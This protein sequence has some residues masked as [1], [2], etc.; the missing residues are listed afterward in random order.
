[1]CDVGIAVFPR[2]L[3]YWNPRVALPN[4]DVHTFLVGDEKG[5]DVRV[6]LDIIRRV[7]RTEYDVAL[8]FSQDQDSSGAA[9]EIRVVAREQNHWIKVVSGYPVSPTVRN[10]GDIDKTGWF[11]IKCA[12]YDGCTDPSDC[13]PE[14]PSG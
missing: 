5:I 4:G 13:R 9:E 8:V 12:L 7:R 2:A 10:R 6:A 3:C 1:M 14:E 11:P